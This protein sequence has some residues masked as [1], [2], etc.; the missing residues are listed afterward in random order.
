M[1]IY[2]I[3]KAASLAVD[4]G[5]LLP[6]SRDINSVFASTTSELGELGVEVMIANGQSYK[7]PGQDGIIGEA[8]DT[9]LCLLD[10]IHLVDP[11]FT[12]GQLDEIARMKCRKWVYKTTEP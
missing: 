5:N 2:E 10:M 9:I 12:E 11:T 1:S 8:V 6:K 3:T 4:A 7:H